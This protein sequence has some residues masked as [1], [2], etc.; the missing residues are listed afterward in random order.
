MVDEHAVAAEAALTGN[1]RACGVGDD[2]GLAERGPALGAGRA[3]TAARHEDHDDVIAL[4]QIVH[5][6]AGFLDDTRALMT[7]HDGERA[8]A[9]AVHDREVGVAEAGGGH[10][11]QHFTGTRPVEFERLD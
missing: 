4:F 3:M 5:T 11:D 1:E 8:R 2:A 6:R 7:D 10:P 9:V